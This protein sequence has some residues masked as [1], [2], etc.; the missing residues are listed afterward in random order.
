MP[1]KSKRKKKKDVVGEVAGQLEKA[2]AKLEKAVSEYLQ[3]EEKAAKEKT[4]QYIVR[5]VGS[6]VVVGGKTAT[7]TFKRKR[8]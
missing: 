4:R 1:K 3:S 8:G 5:A 2:A 7:T 6:N